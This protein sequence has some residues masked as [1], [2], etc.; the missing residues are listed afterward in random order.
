MSQITIQLNK[1]NFNIYCVLY[2]LFLKST[3]LAVKLLLGQKRCCWHRRDWVGYRWLGTR[4]HPRSRHRWDRWK[5][6]WWNVEGRGRLLSW[7][8][9]Y[10]ILLRNNTRWLRHRVWWRRKQTRRRIH[11]RDYRWKIL[12]WRRLCSWWS[13]TRRSPSIRGPDRI[14]RQESSSHLFWI[15]NDNDFKIAFFDTYGSHAGR[16]PVGLGPLALGCPKKEEKK[17]KK[18]KCKY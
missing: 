12:H 13:L 17:R 7:W 8:I 14:N 11:W 9:L 10:R 16:F 3:L 4:R 15:K 2:L 18:R 6:R 5:Y 1:Y